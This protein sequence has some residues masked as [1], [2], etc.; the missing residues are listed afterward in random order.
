MAPPSGHS[1]DGR[2]LP[3]A[4]APTPSPRRRAET[5][6]HERQRTGAWRRGARADVMAPATAC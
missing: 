6:G 4:S 5:D 1:R 2:P 3:Q